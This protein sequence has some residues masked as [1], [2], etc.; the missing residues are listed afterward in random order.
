MLLDTEMALMM[1]STAMNDKVIKTDFVYNWSAIRSLMVFECQ[2]NVTANFL[3]WSRFYLAIRKCPDFS[4]SWRAICASS[5]SNGTFFMVSS[6]LCWCYCLQ[7][8]EV[9]GTSQGRSWLPFSENQRYINFCVRNPYLLLK[10][11]GKTTE[12]L[13][14]IMAGLL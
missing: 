6:S 5:C 4:Y 2:C 9:C 14:G 10:R 11:A 1:N 12:M 3:I 7:S 13:A 8:T